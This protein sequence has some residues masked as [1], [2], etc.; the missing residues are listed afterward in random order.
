[1]QLLLVDQLAQRYRCRP[2]ELL[3]G[4]PYAFQLDLAVAAHGWNEER[5]RREAI[6]RQG[7]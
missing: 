7:Y 5:A 1:M 6:E 3:L 4:D 2:S